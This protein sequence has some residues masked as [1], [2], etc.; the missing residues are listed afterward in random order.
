MPLEDGSSALK[1]QTKG[2]Q[3][4]REALS[5]VKV[6]RAPQQ[7]QAAGTAHTGLTLRFI[8]SSFPCFLA[9]QPL[10]DRKNQCIF[11]ILQG[12]RSYN[13]LWQFNVIF[14]TLHSRNIPS[15]LTL[16]FSHTTSYTILSFSLHSRA[17]KQLGTIFY[18]I[19][20]S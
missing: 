14:S 5:T 8:S 16:Q 4:G 13:C 10:T 19:H 15:Y 18:V 12:K 17:E 6:P 20:R 11:L 3:Q 7:T 9:T 1:M 2:K